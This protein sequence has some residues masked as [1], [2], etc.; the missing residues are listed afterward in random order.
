VNR[1]SSSWPGSDPANR[2]SY[3]RA[4]RICGTAESRSI[5]N[6]WIQ[7]PSADL[8]AAAFDALERVGLNA[9]SAR[10]AIQALESEE[11]KVRT[12]AAYAPP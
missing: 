3:A 6:R 10:L 4:L 8:R 2:L 5:L 7:D 9:S 12:K 1:S 11:I